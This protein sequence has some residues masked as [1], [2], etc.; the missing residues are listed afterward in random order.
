M[1]RG[2]ARIFAAGSACLPTHRGYD[3]RRACHGAR[4]RPRPRRAARGLDGQP[5]GGRPQPLAVQSRCGRRRRARCRARSAQRIVRRTTCRTRSEVDDD[6]RRRRARGAARGPRLLA[7]LHARR[8]TA[9]GAR[10][11]SACSTI[12]RAPARSHSRAAGRR[13]FARARAGACACAAT[14]RTLGKGD[15]LTRALA[16]QRFPP[17][18]MS[19]SRSRSTR[20]SSL[21]RRRRLARACGA[22]SAPHCAQRLPTTARRIAPI[23]H[24]A[25][26][27]QMQIRVG[28]EMIYEC[29]QPDADDPDAERALLARVRT[30][31]SRTT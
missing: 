23:A 18:A 27:S 15:G 21:A 2:Y 30:S 22:A 3:A 31:W 11:T 7:Q 10:P 28:Y 4:P 13:A 6:R 9:C 26:E 5:P 24:R 8:S 25:R 16:P 19:A 20:R 14:I 17:R 12:P 29:P 1:P